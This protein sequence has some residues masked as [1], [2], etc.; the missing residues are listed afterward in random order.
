MLYNQIKELYP[1]LEPL[2]DFI[3]QDDGEG[4]YIKEWFSEES[5]PTKE[6]LADVKVTAIKAPLISEIKR[7][8]SEKIL[9]IAPDWKQRNMIARSVELLTLDPTDESV[10]AE[11]AAMKAAYRR[12]DAIREY[13]NTLEGALDADINTDITEGWPE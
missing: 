10:I 13:S 5:R 2:K 12:L 1:H 7:I 11:R 3:L 6:E 8:A 9:A 4:P